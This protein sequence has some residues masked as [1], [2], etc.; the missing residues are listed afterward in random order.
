MDIFFPD[1][2]ILS[3]HLHLKEMVKIYFNYTSQKNNTDKCDYLKKKTPH[4]DL[5][6]TSKSNN[7]DLS[8]A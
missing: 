4:Y 7:L 3:K 6:K 5:W 2:R 1:Y 8:I